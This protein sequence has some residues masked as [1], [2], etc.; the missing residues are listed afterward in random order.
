MS[1][2]YIVLGLF[3]FGVVYLFWVFPRGEEYGDEGRLKDWT[4]AKRSLL[5]DGE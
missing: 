3:I 4:S 2:S 5:G 1:T